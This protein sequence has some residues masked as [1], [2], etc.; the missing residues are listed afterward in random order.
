MYG[1]PL[2]REQKVSVTGWSAQM[3]TAFVGVDHS[4][5]G[6]NALRPFPIELV[7]LGKLLP[8]TG[9]ESAGFDRCAISR[10]AC[11]PDRKHRLRSRLWSA[12]VWIAQPISKLGWI[13]HPRSK[14]FCASKEV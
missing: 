5:P 11:K 13:L 3:Y 14:A 12:D 8:V 7:N 1:P 10:F 6:W 4:W 9:L 2:R